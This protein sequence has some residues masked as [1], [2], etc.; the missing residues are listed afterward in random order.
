M[1]IAKINSKTTPSKGNRTKRT[2]L[3]CAHFR[4]AEKAYECM[5]DESKPAVLSEKD[6]RSHAT[7][8]N[9][10]VGYKA[11]SCPNFKNAGTLE[12]MKNKEGWNSENKIYKVR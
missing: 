3:D 5:A 4:D 7:R 9:Q 1:I 8:P 11:E 6:S 2:C 10:V 12:A